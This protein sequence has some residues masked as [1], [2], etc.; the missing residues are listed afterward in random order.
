[1]DL[2]KF[3]SIQTGYSAA[4]SSWCWRW[5]TDCLTEI[6]RTP[7]TRF[8][9]NRFW[10]CFRVIGFWSGFWISLCWPEKRTWSTIIVKALSKSRKIILF[11][12]YALSKCIILTLY[13]CPF[14]S[15]C[16]CMLFARNNNSDRQVII[17]KAVCAL[18]V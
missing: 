3:V 6:R 8:P 14:V 15:V 1:M 11:V 10:M 7:K 13:L 5:S 2:H 16:V 12:H 18:F 9:D 4:P 17:Y